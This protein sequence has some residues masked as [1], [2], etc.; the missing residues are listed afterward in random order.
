MTTHRHKPTHGS[1]GNSRR[2]IDWT[3]LHKD[4]RTWLIIGL[5]LAA[6]GTYVLTL[7]DSLQP[8]PTIQGNQPPVADRP[9][10]QN[11]S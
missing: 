7:D 8:G 1:K 6:M 3:G 9:V 4:W 11:D 5:M 2:K 10:P